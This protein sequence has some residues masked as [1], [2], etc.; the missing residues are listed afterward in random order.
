LIILAGAAYTASKHGLVGLTKN[1]AAFYGNKGIKCNAVM[2]GGMNTNIA[3]AFKT[4]MHMEGYQKMASI[5][6]S[7]Q[8]PL[9]DVDEV[10]AFCLNLTY[11]KGAGQINGATIAVDNGWTSIVG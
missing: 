11:G 3:D 10:A 6:E 4:G 5:L 9:M 2:V 1:T 8:T 7:I